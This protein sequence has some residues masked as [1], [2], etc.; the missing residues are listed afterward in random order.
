MSEE[1][2]ILLVEDNPGDVRLVQEAF[3][4]CEA[5]YRIRVARDGEEAADALFREPDGSNGFCPDLV[6]LDLNLPK[7][8]GGELLTE[9][10]ADPELQGMPVLV[11][12]S[13]TNDDDVEAA[14]NEGANAYLTKPTDPIEFFSLA[15]TIEEFWFSA[16]K[17]PPTE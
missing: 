17:R 6:L 15:E 16:A 4:Q 5:E 9:L 10:R 14:Y 3:A 2:S 8:S 7:K 13:S 12:S 1:H 11:L